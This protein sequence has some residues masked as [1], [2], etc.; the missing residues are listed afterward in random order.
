MN[1]EGLTNRQVLVRALKRLV[2]EVEQGLVSAEAVEW[3]KEALGEVVRN[4]KPESLAKIKP[5]KKV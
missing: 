4:K 1:I 2:T 3:A 5:S